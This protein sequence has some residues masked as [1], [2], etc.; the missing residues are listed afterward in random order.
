[1]TEA[2]M[3]E[4]HMIE[5]TDAETISRQLEEDIVLGRILP[6][7]R[8]PEDGLMARFGVKR[9]VVRMALQQ[10]ATTG[11]LDHVPNKGAQVRAF[12]P[13]EVRELYALRDLLE[14]AAAALIPLPLPEAE[15]AA[16]RAAQAP[17]DAA[18]AAGDAAAVFRAN[19]AFHRQ[20]FALCPNRFLVEA[21][22][23]ASARAHGIRFAALCDPA[24]MEQARGD[25][26]AMIAA[27]AEGRRDDQVRLCRDHLPASRAAY[28]AYAVTP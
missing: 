1:M 8:L 6:R 3:T 2:S 25:H 15:V 16:L 9:H 12:S 24:A 4:A 11:V 5:D 7:E 28:L 27:A 20:L 10:L 14:T 13:D 17:H 26:H 21:V 19:L 23:A 22:E 18:V